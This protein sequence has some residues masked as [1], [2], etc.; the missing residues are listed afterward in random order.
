M[1]YGV[2]RSPKKQQ[3]GLRLGR[4]SLLAVGSPGLESQKFPD[5]PLAK[6]HKDLKSWNRRPSETVSIQL[7]WWDFVTPEGGDCTV[8]WLEARVTNRE[9]PKMLPTE[10]ER[11]QGVSNL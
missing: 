7:F 1:R 9:H 5:Q 6:W 11:G 4:S 8:A 3:Q 2:G 10:R